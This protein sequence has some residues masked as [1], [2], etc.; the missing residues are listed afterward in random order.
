MKKRSFHLLA[1]AGVLTSLSLVLMAGVAANQTTREVNQ[2]DPLAPYQTIDAAVE[3]ALPGDVILVH[4][5]TYEESVVI[6]GI[7][8]KALRGPEVTVIQS[9]DGTGDGVTLTGNQNVAL[10]GLRVQGFVRGV[11]VSTD[12]GST[13]VANCVV[14]GNSS[15]GIYLDEAMPVSAKIVNNISADNGGSGVCATGRINSL[16]S[17]FNNIMFRNSNYGFESPKQNNVVFGD[18]NCAFGNSQNDFEGENHWYSDSAGEHAIQTDPL[19]DARIHYRFTSQSS[20]AVNT[21]HPSSFYDDPDGSQND[22]G[23]YGGPEAANWWRD[24]FAGP[25]VEDVTIDPPQISPGGLVTIRATART[26]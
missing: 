11:V 3:D 10:V 2:N 4:P 9:P 24:P 12:G 7:T 17:V 19:I 13:K 5:G 16:T 20:P 18:Y 8:L 21:G 22:M 1:L 25:T 14:T 26:E 15:H 23:A 6:S